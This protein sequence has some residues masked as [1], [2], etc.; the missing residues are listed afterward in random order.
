MCHHTRIAQPSEPLLLA[1]T[2]SKLDPA[3]DKAFPVD[4][5]F[6]AGRSPFA[7]GCMAARTVVQHTATHAP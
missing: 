5:L 4:E 7:L 3:N 1:Y 2:A 6:E